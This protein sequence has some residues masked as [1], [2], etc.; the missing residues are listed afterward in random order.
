[1][2]SKKNNTRINV[3][4]ALRGFALVSIMLLHNIE[5]FEV[6]G[7][8]PTLPGWIVNL[9]K[10]I[11]DTFFFLFGGKSYA[12]FALLFG[13]TFYIQ[14]HHQ[15]EEGKGFRLRFIWRMLLLA[16]FGMINTLFYRGEILVFYAILGAL[17]MLLPLKSMSNKVILILAIILL[18]QP[19]LSVKLIEALQNPAMTTPTPSFM[20]FYVA[21]GPF[22]TGDSMLQLMISN[23]TDG[24]I[25]SLLWLLEYGRVEQTLGLFLLGFLAGRK[26][27]FNDTPE[28]IKFWI[29]VLITA[30]ILFIPL[31]ILKNNPTVFASSKNISASIS[32]IIALWSNLALMFVLMSGFILL[33]YNKKIQP[34]LNYLSP[35]G[36]MSMTNYILQSIIGASLYYGFGLG[37]YRYAGATYCLVIGIA[38]TIAMGLWSSYWMKNHKRGI[39]ESIWH[40]LTWLNTKKND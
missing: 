7:A 11:W 39:F 17:L 21:S 12:I 32:L 36:K 8:H 14:T 34:V 6:H 9:D 23:I 10:I 25:A 27:I 2:I 16:V 24:R 19:I 1:M 13:L 35:I 20:P 4:D 38:L 33:F 29:K 5:V 3:V 31:H 40:Q 26:G 22:L 30:A 15:E 18:C 28:N 37:L